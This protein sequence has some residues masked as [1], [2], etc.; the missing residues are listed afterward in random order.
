MSDAT[1]PQEKL[2]L[3]STAVDYASVR[4]S[5][6][7]DDPDA[8]LA[9]AI[10]YGKTATVRKE[11]LGKESRLRVSSRSLPLTKRSGNS[12]ER[13]W[14]WRILGLRHMAW[15]D[16]NVFQRGNGAD[17]LRQAARSTYEEAAQC[18][19]KAIELNPI[20]SCTTSNWDAS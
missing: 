6:E 13:D 18:F 14:Y 19:E 12:T 7:P 11:N 5:L 16:V 15:A 2:S 9:V 8:E 10:S 1:Q 4:C 3:G 20:G 17:R